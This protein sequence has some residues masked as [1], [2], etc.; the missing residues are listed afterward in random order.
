MK[1]IIIGGSIGGLFAGIELSKKGFD[2]EIYERSPGDL[3]DRG[4][5][6]VIQPDMMD[7]MIGSGISSHEKFGVM[8]SQ[9]QVLNS[10]G[11]PEHIYPNDTVFTSWNYLWYQLKSAFPSQKYFKGYDLEDIED[12]NES[13]K[14]RFKNGEIRY[15]DLLIG[16]DGLNSVVRNYVSEGIY[17][18]FAG[19]VAFR[20]LIPE[21]E[22]SPEEDRFFENKFSIF[23]YRGSHL[24][25]YLIPGKNG[26]TRHGER[27][28]N[29]VWYQNKSLTEL[30]ALL[31]DKDGRI[32][33]FSVPAGLLHVRATAE[34][35]KILSDR[36]IQTKNPFLQVISDLSVPRMYKGRI[37]VLGDS[38]HLVRPHTASGTAKAYRDAISLSIFLG[39]ADD[40]SQS[41]MAWNNQQMEHAHA[42]NI[43]GRQLALRSQ[44]GF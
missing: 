3:V 17:P 31:K 19:Y 18:N 26:S 41:L 27:L 8:A 24:L 32:R 12:E 14:A 6:L 30:K 43:H 7:Y 29:W 35:P 1:V 37:V 5:G 16:A 4:A 21:M 42:L 22:L 9:R 15:G 33:T 44:L 28:L 13:V 20:G 40:L 25:S 34:L 23:P 36:V 38:A 39:E 10:Q 2:V 11:Q